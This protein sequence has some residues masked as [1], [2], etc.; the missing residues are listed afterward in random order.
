MNSKIIIIGAGHGGLYAA[1]ILAD[2]GADVTVYEKSAFDKISHDRTDCIEVK[3]FKETGLPLPEGSY[4]GH[5][6]SFVGPY[7][8]EMM[9]IYTEEPIRDIT[10]GRK[11]FAHMLINRAE[12][13]GV[14]FVFE[15]EVEALIVE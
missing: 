15:T 11:A 9:Y 13:S 3:L 4:T 10:V 5:C 2:A 7:T 14:K 1:K 8:D 6:C 12:E